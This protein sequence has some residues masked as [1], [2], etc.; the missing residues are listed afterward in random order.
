M[1]KPENLLSLPRFS[2]RENG[3]SAL[4][5]KENYLN[6]SPLIQNTNNVMD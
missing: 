2:N 1:I 4:F 3:L 5:G 6:R